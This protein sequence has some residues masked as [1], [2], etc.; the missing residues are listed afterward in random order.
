MT[1]VVVDP[2]GET[3]DVDTSNNNWP[4][5]KAVPTRFQVFKAHKQKPTLNPMQRAQGKTIKP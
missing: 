4:V 3:P 1:A 2:L 5:E